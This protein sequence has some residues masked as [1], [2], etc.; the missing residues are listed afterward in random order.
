[1]ALFGS[2][3]C[4]AV[5]LER[6]TPRVLQKVDNRWKADVLGVGGLFRFAV[7]VFV[8]VRRY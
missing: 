3:P 2:N 5:G 8:L 7:E 4:L 6:Q 1:V